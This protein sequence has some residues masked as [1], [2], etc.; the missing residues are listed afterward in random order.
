MLVGHREVSLQSD[1]VDLSG[2]DPGYWEGGGVHRSSRKGREFES[3]REFG[4]PFSFQSSTGRVAFSK[5]F[6]Q[7]KNVVLR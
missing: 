7:R 3:Q 2:A 5:V 4:V 1:S 6:L